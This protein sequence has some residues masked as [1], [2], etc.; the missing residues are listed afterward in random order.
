MGKISNHCDF[1]CKAAYPLHTVT[2]SD[3]KKRVDICDKCLQ[4]AKE[5]KRISPIK[6]NNT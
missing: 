6:E 2:E 3:S 1:C 4:W 5:E